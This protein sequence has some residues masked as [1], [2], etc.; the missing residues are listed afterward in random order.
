MHCL[1][2]ISERQWRVAWLAILHNH[3]VRSAGS[4]A[5]ITALLTNDTDSLN[6]NCI[7]IST[8]DAKVIIWEKFYVEIQG[9]QVT[10]IT[11]SWRR[12]CKHTFRQTDRQ[13]RS[14]Q[15]SSPLSGGVIKMLYS[16]R[17]VGLSKLTSVYVHLHSTT[18]MFAWTTSRQPC[19][20]YCVFGER[21]ATA[22]GPTDAAADS[23][24]LLL[25]SPIAA[26]ITWA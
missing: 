5:N 3:Y 12:P 9:G 15:Y 14:S 17:E 4:L 11:P 6:N 1:S 8:L 26:R 25:S 13:T 22:C 16:K 20:Y 2:G 10:P 21:A 19:I 23:I 18:R 7:C 24:R